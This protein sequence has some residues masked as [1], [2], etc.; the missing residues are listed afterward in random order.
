MSN[1]KLATYEQYKHIVNNLKLWSQQKASYETAKDLHFMDME[2]DSDDLSF[3]CFYGCTFTTCTFS[4]LRMVNTSFVN[5]VFE[6]CVFED[7]NLIQ[8]CFNCSK[9]AGSILRRNNLTKIYIRKTKF[10]AT[11]L[12]DNYGINI[13]LDSV[14]GDTFSAKQIKAEY[15]NLSSCIVKMPKLDDSFDYNTDYS[16]EEED[17][18][19]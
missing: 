12:Y 6:D 8:A 18:D 2:F 9:I 17:D 3:A 4:N 5:C 19:E 16:D 7:C 1:D 14:N 11:K 13:R 10:I 15:K